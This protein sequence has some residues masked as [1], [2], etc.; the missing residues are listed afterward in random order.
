MKNIIHTLIL[1]RPDDAPVEQSFTDKVMQRI[2]TKQPRRSHV[3][4]LRASPVLTVVAVVLAIGL[5]SGAAYA[6]VTY[7]WPAP[8]VDV[9]TPTE[10]VSGRKEVLIESESCGDEATL[11]RY[12]L[13]K[14]ATITPKDLPRVAKAECELAA[15]N[16]WIM[17]EFPSTP[18]PLD[19]AVLTQPGYEST[20]A[21]VLPAHIADKVQ[22]ISVDKLVVAAKDKWNPSVTY[23][24]SQNVKYIADRQAKDIHS[25]HPG[26]PIIVV[27]KNTVKVRNDADCTPKHCGA[28]SVSSHDEVLAIV[29]L[30]GTYDDYRHGNSLTKLV[31][32]MGNEEDYCH[33]GQGG[34]D[35]V[36]NYRT[37]RYAIDESGKHNIIEGTVTAHDSSSVTIRTTSGRL[38]RIGTDE[39]IIASFNTYRSADYE[40]TTLA[41]GDTLVINYIQTSDVD[42]QTI[43]VDTVTDID[44]MLETQSKGDPINK[45]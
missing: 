19:Q 40:G 17:K 26:D 18:P 10:S 1:S 20:Q 28:S 21:S 30:E 16:K 43:P 36:N 13:K 7:L 22:S 2:A 9:G 37:Q 24:L 31:P 15:I 34:I 32:C 39:D 3:S 33:E 5:L 35:L 25:I 45:Y 27:I 29:K 23:S 8:S 4:L 38:V 12:E 6:A 44:V 41:I 11:Q 42:K 14:T